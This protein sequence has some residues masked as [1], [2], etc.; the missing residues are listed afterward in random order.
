[1]I[2][3]A[4][5]NRSTTL[6]DAE[7]AAAAPAFDLQIQR[8]VAPAWGINAKLTFYAKGQI[9]PANAWQV[10]VLDNSDQAG[11]LGYHDLTPAGYP[12]SKVFAATDKAFKLSWTVTTS[13]EICEMLVDPDCVL[14]AQIN[15][16]TFVAY[17]LCDPVEADRF[18]YL[19][20]GVLVSDFVLPSYFQPAAHKPFDFMNRLTRPLTLL[21]GG[22][23][24]LW[25][26]K[27]GWAQ[28]NA[29]AA[30][31]VTSRAQFS[32]R[33]LMRGS[34]VLARSTAEVEVETPVV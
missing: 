23:L 14:A 26:P 30:P 1:M 25:T 3:L 29:D 31:G 7:V 13:H 8:D 16:T 22:Y 20:N 27:G 9:P 5:M 15:D 4:L 34:V 6:K 10:L 24:S 12:L 11:A 17:E 21:P 2:Q 33:H 28:K 32:T 19:I 18:G